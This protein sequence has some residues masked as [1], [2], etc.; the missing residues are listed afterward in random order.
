MSWISK[1]F[2][3]GGAEPPLPD[4]EAL[5]APHFPILQ[6][7]SDARLQRMRELVPQ[8]WRRLRWSAAGGLELTDEMRAVITANA[9]LPILGL[10]FALYSRASEI[11]VYPRSYVWPGQE[12][13]ERLGETHEWGTIV[14]SWDDVRD[15]WLEPEQAVNPA[16]HEFAHILDRA[17][18]E[19][20]GTPPLP[21]G[22]LE[23]WNKVMTK[24]FESLR[25]G[26]GKAA[27]WLDEYGGEN[28]T[29]F[30][31]VVTEAF[32][33]D[34]PVMS[35][36]LPDLYLELKRFYRQDPAREYYEDPPA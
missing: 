9:C 32:F 24:H 13:E 17:D 3:R 26:K 19:F 2:G 25:K 8:F 10:D 30:F 33:M 11:I 7:L 15:A 4:W 31:A 35:E 5:C 18:G 14:L 6:S 21:R 29:E 16:I 22:D 28:E 34:A 23:R 1:I 36:E 27:E 12:E 20:D